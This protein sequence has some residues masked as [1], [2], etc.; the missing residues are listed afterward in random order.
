MSVRGTR[1][2]SSPAAVDD[3]DGA[4]PA[5]VARVR[6]FAELFESIAN[7]DTIA[8]LGDSSLRGVYDDSRQIESRGVFVAVCG[9]AADGR[10][11]VAD[12]ARRGAAVIVAEGAVDG[13]GVPVVTVPDARAALARL[14]QRWY[15]V[16]Q[17][18][19][20]LPKLLGVTGTNGKSTVAFMTRAI[21]RAAGQR[22]GMLGTLEY[23]L[24]SHRCA[25]PLTTPGALRLAECLRACVDARAD[26]VVM[27]VSSHALD[28][29]RTAGLRFEAAALTNLTRDHLDY[30]GTFEAY[31]AAKARL[32]AGL[33]ADSVAVVN[34]DDPAHEALVADCAARVV[35]YGLDH[36]TDIHGA[37][38]RETIAGTRMRL[39]I[40]GEAFACD[41]R[42]VGR[43]NVANALA[44][45][46]L[47]AALGVPGGVIAEGL[48]TLPG[49]PGRLHR[50]R[51]IDGPAV[52]VDYAHTPDALQKV[53]DVLRP[54]A[55]RRLIVVFGCGGERD[56]GKRPDMARAVGRAADAIVLTSDNPRREDPQ[57][58]VDDT[59]TGFDGE[60][61]RRVTVESD[62]AA[63]ITC[64]LA[65]A[66]DGDIVLIAGKGH[67]DYQMVG[68]Q[69]R[70]FDDVEA[71]LAAADELGL[72]RAAPSTRQE[73][74]QTH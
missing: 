30:H 7:A 67:E 58:I 49:V 40:A 48:A 63:A 42:I 43:H 65:A 62:R 55:R 68:T 32:F 57:Q 61:R 44:A 20:T 26:V 69:R 64:A 45:A 17:G 3:A 11:F 18:A 72:R 70:H 14:A 21:L 33:P 59:L 23:D 13:G 74:G 4:A 6:T 34:R 22:V 53:L 41:S 27:E 66:S 35:R 19:A 1:L 51:E 8:R 37:I 73:G 25:A 71:A 16:E 29:Q 60:Q 39:T 10:R 56:R 31:G 38:L 2:A 5:K 36:Q 50:V 52:F 15:D 47:A 46:G 9:S 24:V 54:L 28:Q 12:A